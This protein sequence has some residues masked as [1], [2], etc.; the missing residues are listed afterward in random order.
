MRVLY[1][2]QVFEMQNFGGISRYFV[3]LFSEATKYEP[4]IALRYSNNLHLRDHHG[5]QYRVRPIPDLAR[6]FLWGMEFRGKGRLYALMQRA[7][8]RHLPEAANAENSLETLGRGDFDLFHPTYYDPYFLGSLGRRPFVL[9]VYDMIHEI[10]P[11]YFR[12]TDATSSRKRTLCRRAARIIAISHSTKNDLIEIFGIEPDKIDVVYLASSLAGS[13]GSVHVE[14]PLPDRYILFTGSRWGYKNFPFLVRNISEILL[15]QISL[16]LVCTGDPFDEQEKEFFEAL[17][18][19]HLVHHRATISDSELA[20]LYRGAEMFVFPSL[21][22][23]FGVPTLEA[24]ACRCPVLLSD[25][26][27]MRE[28]AGDAA[29]YFNPKNS[30]ELRTAVKR[31]LE[32]EALRRTLVD[33]GLKVISKYSWGKT[34]LETAEV[35]RRALGR[36]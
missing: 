20:R 24:F 29:L 33:R 35:Y 8:R 18:I 22:E 15:S 27:V 6:G 4:E 26:P 14:E 13:L 21:Y 25:I 19:G 36:G 9:T 31:V 16:N 2:H 10:F 34:R 23:G 3:E 32:D 28:I 5:L 17:S 12:L 30:S 1:D 11:E 7:L